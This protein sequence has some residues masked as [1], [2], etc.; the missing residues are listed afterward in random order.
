MHSKGGPTWKAIVLRRRAKIQELSLSVE[1]SKAYAMG[2][3]FEQYQRE[4]VLKKDV[5]TL[6]GSSLNELRR[7]ALIK[8]AQPV[9]R[10]KSKV[11]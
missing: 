8:Q 5:R 9:K 11:I 6:L 1:I 7:K 4:N 10:S 3:E 2:K